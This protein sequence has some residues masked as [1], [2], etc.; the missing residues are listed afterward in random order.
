MWFLFM[1]EDLRTRETLVAAVEEVVVQN[2]ESF[3]EEYAASEA[4]AGKPK[5]RTNN[6]V[7]SKVSRKGIVSPRRN[8]TSQ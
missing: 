2:Y 8:D 7:S 4:G 1:L 6:A 5:G 3:F